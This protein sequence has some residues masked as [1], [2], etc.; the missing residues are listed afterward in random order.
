[1]IGAFKRKPV[2]HGLENRIA[3]IAA[4]GR[5]VAAV[6]EAEADLETE[7]APP[8]S[9]ADAA[10]A[11]VAEAAP[12]APPP[13]GVAQAAASLPEAAKPAVQ[14]EVRQ[15]PLG[16]GDLHLIAARDE[17]VKQLATEISS[18]QRA[19]LHRG[20]IAKLVDHAVARHFRREG[21]PINAG[22]RRRL[23]TDVMQ[24]LTS[25]AEARHAPVSTSGGINI[26][27]IE[28]ARERIHP[29]VIE[30]LDVTAAAAMPRP[31]FEAQLNGWVTDLLAEAK[32][33]LNFVEHR[34]LVDL[35]VADM[36]GLGPIDT[37]MADETV[38][39]IMI[40]GHKQIYVE[41]RGKVELTDIKFRDEQ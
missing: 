28:A 15:G 5:Q 16:P 39:D 27:V 38:S 2:N 32:I 20:D 11:G 26:A 40:N 8:P 34:K 31:Q 1:M 25:M 29:R 3:G 9:A 14:A 24:E 18:E 33:Q 19:V 41:R 22:M 36:L 17:L 13:E 12:A 4:K 35:L 10:A 7:A 23:V 30:Q 6:T 21:T 37:L